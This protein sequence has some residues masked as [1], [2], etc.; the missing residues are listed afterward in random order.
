MN[1][2]FTSIDVN[3]DQPIGPIQIRI[4]SDNGAL[5]Q[6]LAGD[7]LLG[8]VSTP[9]PDSL[10]IDFAGLVIGTADQTV[11][12]AG[13]TE[14]LKALCRRMTTLEVSSLLYRT[15]HTLLTELENRS[16]VND[17]ARHLAEALY[18]K[19]GQHHG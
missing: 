15:Y 19:G 16:D 8:L 11:M 4:T 3:F 10:G 6:R 9:R 18:R 5:D 7:F 14:V 17:F 13:I 1:N 2:E 12:E